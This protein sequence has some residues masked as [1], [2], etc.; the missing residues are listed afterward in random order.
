MIALVTDL[1]S[2]LI[3]RH[4]G[5]GD[6]IGCSRSGGGMSSVT[7]V[8]VGKDDLVFVVCGTC[9]AEGFRH[10]VQKAVADD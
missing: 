5:S 1:G 4:D 7:L 3:D 6:C 9:I 8:E 10:V 2:I